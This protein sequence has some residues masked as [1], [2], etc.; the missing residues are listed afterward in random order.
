V[1]GSRIR[2]KRAVISSETVS[3]DEVRF[4]NRLWSVVARTGSVSLI[5]DSVLIVWVLVVLVMHRSVRLDRV[6]D[7]GWNLSAVEITIIEGRS[8]VRLNNDLLMASLWVHVVMSTSVVRL[9]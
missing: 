7:W 3:L 6:V 4:S 8:V 1:K 2:L 9:T 5:E